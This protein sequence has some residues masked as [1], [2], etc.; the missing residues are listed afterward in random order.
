MNLSEAIAPLKP[1]SGDRLQMD[2]PSH[3][4]KIQE[5]R[6]LKVRDRNLGGQETGF[7]AASVIFLQDLSQKPGFGDWG[8]G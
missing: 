7:L 5:T 4:S 1:P 2:S 6:F 3:F 8:M